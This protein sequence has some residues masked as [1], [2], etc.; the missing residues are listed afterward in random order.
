MQKVKSKT[1]NKI[2]KFRTKK[3][4][5]QPNWATPGDQDRAAAQPEQAQPRSPSLSHAA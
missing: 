5:R 1:E 4:G 2:E 3:K